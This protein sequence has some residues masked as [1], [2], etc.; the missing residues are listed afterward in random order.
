[1]VSYDPMSH[2]GL[3]SAAQLKIELMFAGVRYSEALERAAEHAF[4]NFYPY[5][6]KAGEPNPTGKSKVT[7]PY[8]MRLADGT[9]IRVK[10]ARDSAWVV[11]G[12]R[13]NGYRLVHDQGRAV[14]VAFEPLPEWMRNQT[15]DGFS[16]AQ[17]G[18][19]LHGDMAV[20]NVAPGCEYFLARDAHGDSMRCVFCAYGAPNERVRHFEQSVG[21]ADVPALTVRRMQET[22]AA[23]LA[24]TQIHHIYLVGGSMTDWAKEGERFIALARTVQAIN[25]QRIPVSCGSG[26]LPD[27]LLVA[28]HEEGTVDHVCFNLE[29]WSE[30][31]FA[32]ICPGKQRYVG[33][34]RWLESLERAVSLWGPGR[35]Y[36]AMVAGIELE[37]E[38]GLDWEQAADL[39][40][41]G[42]R[43]LCRRGILPIYSLYWPV[44]GRDHP[45]YLD[46]L[47]TYFARLNLGYKA[48]RDRE[49]LEIADTFMC[50]RCAYMQLECDIDRAEETVVHA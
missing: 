26:A 15:S 35:V 14:P 7:I 29:V 28:L 3:P 24:E 2:T 6:F 20:I 9:L 10:G 30:E 41:A 42:A 19:S 27:D 38:H 31:L 18:V 40:V 47:R 39:A 46:R 11:Q 45:D 36:S 48:I 33:Y 25:D 12:D 22:L 34:G 5:R 16:M 1:M 32:R 50:H 43:E 44:G 4:P 37:P 23:A 8:L 13:L 21:T 49:G 17:A